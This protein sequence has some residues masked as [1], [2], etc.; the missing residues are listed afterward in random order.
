MHTLATQ[1]AG[2]W[3]I[4]LPEELGM[5]DNSG[6]L[7]LSPAEQTLYVVTG[8]GKLGVINSADLNSLRVSRIADLGV[9]L[10]ET[11]HPVMA[12]G[13]DHLWISMHR[14]LLM[15]DPISLEVQG[16]PSSTRRDRPHPRPFDRRAPGRQRR[17]APAM[18]RRRGRSGHGGGALP[19][20]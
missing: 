12:A 2:V 9:A 19:T 6:A 20:S 14:E 1:F 7:A 15:V 13:S 4:D 11:A 3:C 10:G 18:D 8:A 16:A 17:A 5:T